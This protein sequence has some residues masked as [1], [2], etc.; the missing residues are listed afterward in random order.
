[1]VR[2]LGLFGRALFRFTG[3]F[4]VEVEAFFE[5]L[6]VVFGAAIDVDAFQG[7]VVLVVGCPNS[8]KFAVHSIL[9]RSHSANGSVYLGD[10]MQLS[11]R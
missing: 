2:S 8:G 10:R 3:H 9:R 1:M 11:S 4:G 6:S 7:F 5:A